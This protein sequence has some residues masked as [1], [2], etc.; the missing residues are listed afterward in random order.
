MKN[1]RGLSPFVCSIE[2]I[3]IYF[4][5]TETS[6]LGGIHGLD[7][8]GEDIR[9]HVVSSETAF[10]WLDNGRVDSAMPVIALQWFRIH[11][12]RIRQQRLEN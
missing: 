12:D 7:E 1:N 10:K 5:R 3:D 4:A 8:E 9:V 2:Q 6:G 11:R